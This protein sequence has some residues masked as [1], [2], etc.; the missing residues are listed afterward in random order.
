MISKGSPPSPVCPDRADRVGTKN[1]NL[2]N[3]G[4]MT[5]IIAIISSLEGFQQFKENPHPVLSTKWW[6]QG[7]KRDE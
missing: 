3:V 2:L 6:I 4:M 7:G 1:D 5:D